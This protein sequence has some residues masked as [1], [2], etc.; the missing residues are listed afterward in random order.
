MD[1][2]ERSA[3]CLP[4]DTPAIFL[5]AV[6]P[7]LVPCCW[8]EI[9]K[10]DHVEYQ[11]V[12]IPEI[13]KPSTDAI[14]TWEY[15][16]GTGWLALPG[17]VDGTK[18]FS[19]SGEITFRCPHDISPVT[20]NGQE[21]LWIRVRI[22]GGDYG[23]E[24]FRYDPNTGAVTSRSNFRPP[25]IRSLRIGYATA[26]VEPDAC[27]T[28]NNLEYQDE[29]TAMR[30][31][32]NITPFLAMSDD[33]HQGVYLGF[34]GHPSKG[35]ISIFFALEEQPYSEENR[36]QLRWEYRRSR[37]TDG[38]AEW[39]QLD[40]PVEETGNLT[41]SG[42]IQFMGPEDF[43]SESRLGK[44]S[45]YWVRAVDLNDS[46]KPSAE[47]QRQST[48]TGRPDKTVLDVFHP[49]FS[50][51][52][53]QRSIPPAPKVS[54]IHLNT[55]WAIQ[56]ETMS[57]EI[58][59]SGTSSRNLSLRTAKPSVMEEEAVWVDEFGTLSDSERRELGADKS[60][61]T[62]PE[63]DERGQV[64]RF[65]IRW[66]SIEDLERAEATERAYALDRA[67]GEIR[68]GDGVHG[69]PPPI[70]ANNIHIA[71]RAGGG[72]S[73]NVAAGQIT[74]L[75]TTIPFVEGVSNPWPAGGGS[76]AE[77]PEQ[78]LERGPQAIKHR[79]RAVTVGDYEWLAKAASRAVARVKVLPNVND[80]GETETNWVIVIVVPNSSEPQPTPSPQLRQQVQTYLQQRSANMLVQ[81]GHLLVT[82]PA[83]VEV[84]V[85]AKLIAPAIDRAPHAEIEAL[86][87]L[88][89]FLHPLTGGPDHQG[90]QFGRA[91]NL[92]DFY[93]LLES[94]SGV[95]HVREL[96]L[97]LRW[98][99][100]LD[101]VFEEM[102]ITED[103]PMMPDLPEYTLI[104]SGAH[105]ITV[106]V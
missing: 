83:Y 28:Y 38:K 7:W 33:E 92:S 22:T 97:S 40:L 63:A 13:S 101:G 88:R 81:P 3:K 84:K 85:T 23:K 37:R 52:S 8:P 77:L 76:D 14:L 21:N 78:I 31:K 96:R 73:G 94:I 18:R 41:Q 6:K 47:A 99:K 98:Q 104:F 82:G 68:F 67:S 20:V 49:I 86:D 54:G 19:I 80:Q 62:K 61:Q 29:T 64:T 106:E 57:D 30:D 27:L 90:W 74:A 44:P 32:S 58:L 26:K 53:D 39:A 69:L 91:P 66:H 11:V 5:P 24:E 48:P 15:W 42:T 105:Q 103:E 17:L 2:V 71:Y 1:D 35:P 45:L 25:L 89:S 4:V 36:P 65:W 34:D 16:N 87:R 93:A 59:G 12:S 56:A 9:G 55:A 43:A 102:T 51:P 95:D 50:V 70:G 10:G 72:A 60:L 75:R 100:G 46:F 79:D